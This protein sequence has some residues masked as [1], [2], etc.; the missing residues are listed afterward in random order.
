MDIEKTGERE[1]QI[2]GKLVRKDM[3]GNWIGDPTMTTQEV[4]KFQQHIAAEMASKEYH[5]HPVT[6]KTV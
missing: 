2:N 4:S 6:H 5:Q 1:Y 3:E